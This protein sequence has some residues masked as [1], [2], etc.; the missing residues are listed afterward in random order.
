MHEQNN[1]FEESVLTTLIYISQLASRSAAVR[2][3]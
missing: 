3:T 1:T 2:E